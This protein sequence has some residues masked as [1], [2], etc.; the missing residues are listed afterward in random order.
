MIIRLAQPDCV[1]DAGSWCAR[2][3]G[4]IEND[5][6]A[7]YSDSVISSGVAVL[8][9]LTLAVLARKLLHRAITRLIEVMLNGAGHHLPRPAPDQ[10]ARPETD[11]EKKI[12]QERRTARG[13]A[14]GSVLRSASTLLV[15]TVAITMIL[16]EFG[17]NLGPII[18]SAGIIGLALGFGAQSLVRD[19]LSGIMMLME[20]QYGV[21][22]VVDFG[23]AIG[24]VEAV[25]LRITTLRD[26]SG[27]VWYVRNGEVLRVGNSSQGHAVAVVDLPIGHRADVVAALELA[28]R[29]MSEFAEKDQESARDLVEPPQV[30]GVEAISPQGIT[31]RITAKVRTGQQWAVQRALLA[32]I[33]EAFADAGIPPPAV[34]GLGNPPS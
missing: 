12:Q 11:H 32:T 34:T 30:L 14:I 20:N 17:I 4:L 7:R 2:I 8:F 22:D 29:V 1:A 19:F 15:A 28:A 31:L 18:A 24:T 25:G 33:Q 3:Y 13:R 5:F 21:G 16:G 10:A 23:E 26:I 6:L 9:I 27:T